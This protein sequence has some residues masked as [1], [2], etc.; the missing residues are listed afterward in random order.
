MSVRFNR[1]PCIAHS[2]PSIDIHSIAHSNP[3][4]TWPCSKDHRIRDV[5]SKIRRKSWPCSKECNARNVLSRIRR[6]TWSC[7]KECCIRIVGFMRGCKNTSATDNI[8]PRCLFS[9]MFLNTSVQKQQRHRQCRSYPFAC[10][11]EC[12]RPYASS[13]KVSLG[14]IFQNVSLASMECRSNR[15]CRKIV[16]AQMFHRM[17]K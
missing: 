3:R 11:W 15:R 10:F 9:Q 12:L 17:S 14:I 1:G 8:R 6:R 7:S 2:N 4:K 5:P 13:A 16:F